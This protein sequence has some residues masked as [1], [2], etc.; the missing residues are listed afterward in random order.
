MWL[1]LLHAIPPFCSVP[2]AAI[3]GRVEGITALLLPRSGPSAATEVFRDGN[4]GDYPSTF[5]RVLDTA[6]SIRAHWS[7]VHLSWQMAVATSAAF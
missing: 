6:D 7:C 2:I 4:E 1:S 5:R 3:E